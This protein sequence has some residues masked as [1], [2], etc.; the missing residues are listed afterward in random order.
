MGFGLSAKFGATVSQIGIKQNRSLNAVHT[1]F[2]L[3]LTQFT[4]QSFLLT[5]AFGDVL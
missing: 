4:R 5:Q 1:D 3:Q 2:S